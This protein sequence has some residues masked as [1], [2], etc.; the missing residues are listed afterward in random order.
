M[1]DELVDRII[2]WSLKS[3]IFRDVILLVSIA[4]KKE[5]KLCSIQDV[6]A[7][8]I[9]FIKPNHGKSTNFNNH[10]YFDSYKG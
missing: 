5:G 6:K 9:P 2:L 8:K 1:I 3:N 7:E 4:L 10:N